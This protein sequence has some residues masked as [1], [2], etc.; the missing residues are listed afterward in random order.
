MGFSDAAITNHSGH[1]E[2][3]G[4]AAKHLLLV[5]EALVEKYGLQEIAKKLDGS[6]RKALTAVEQAR[7]MHG[8]PGLA[9]SALEILSVENVLKGKVSEIVAG[10]AL[11][12]DEAMAAVPPLYRKRALAFLR[13]DYRSEDATS[14]AGLTHNGF[15]GD[16]FKRLAECQIKESFYKALAADPSMN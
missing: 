15:I 4:Q 3:H 7:G 11:E 8:A 6:T 2:M 5:R 10:V 16:V 14:N 9:K 13:G 1:A 12:A